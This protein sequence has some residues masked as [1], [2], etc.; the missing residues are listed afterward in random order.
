ML[1]VYYSS[2][3]LFLGAELIYGMGIVDGINPHPKRYAVRLK[4]VEVKMPEP[5][6]LRRQRTVG[7]GGKLQHS[8]VIGLP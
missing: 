7:R 4:S 1:W 6:P 2:L 8:E 5:E 3:N